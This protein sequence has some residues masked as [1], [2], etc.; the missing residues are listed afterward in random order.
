[1]ALDFPSQIREFVKIMLFPL[2]IVPF[3]REIALFYTN[4]KLTNSLVC[5]AK[6]RDIILMSWTSGN[7]LGFRR[8]CTVAEIQA[9]V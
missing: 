5:E 6:S 4:L 8:K 1:M 2:K 3:L 7:L 9:S